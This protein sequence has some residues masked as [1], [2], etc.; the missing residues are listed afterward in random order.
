MYFVLCSIS[1]AYYGCIKH[2]LI[3]MFCLPEIH[4]LHAGKVCTDIQHTSACPT[5]MR[6]IAIL[7]YVDNS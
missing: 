3:F 6:Y 1:T 5:E 2:D 7:Y 4:V